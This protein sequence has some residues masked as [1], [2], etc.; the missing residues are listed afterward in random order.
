MAERYTEIL[1]EALRVHIASSNYLADV[2]DA[3]YCAQYLRAWLGEVQ[4][5]SFLER[6][7]GEGWFSRRTAGDLLR[8]LWLRGQEFTVEE[9][10]QQCGCAPLD[11]DMLIAEAV[12]LAG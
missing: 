8:E 12:S 9:I 11:A 4:L 2:D 3:L 5:R 7:F 6:E 1:S 10:L